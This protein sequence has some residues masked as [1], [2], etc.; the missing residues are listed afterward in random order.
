L[1]ENGKEMCVREAITLDPKTY[2]KPILL[3]IQS[4]ASQNN[5]KEIREARCCATYTKVPS[6]IQSSKAINSI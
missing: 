6:V 5:I 1:I 4:A 2:S 3:A